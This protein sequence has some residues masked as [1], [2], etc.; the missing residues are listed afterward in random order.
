MIDRRKRTADTLLHL[1]SFGLVG[2]VTIILFSVGSVSLLTTD[3]KPLLTG[4]GGVD[5]VFRHI[6]SN[7]A[8]IPAP[9]YPLALRPTNIPAP[10]P[11]QG[12]SGSATAEITGARSGPELP[13]AEHDAS[14]TTLEVR[15]TALI[16]GFQITNPN[17]AEVGGS[18]QASTEPLPEADEPSARAG[19]SG[20]TA[21]SEIPEGRDHSYH[22]PEIDQNQ[23]ARL[24]QS[25]IISD[26]KVA[27]YKKSG[28]P[29][30]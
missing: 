8:L 6:N 17:P 11:P 24:D 21:P 28:A 14:T 7:A 18:D 26:A 4:S 12:A 19:V 1:V 30:S 27:S 16:Q 13:S 29:S 3:K 22:N 25:N 5:V 23:P 20:P 10:L 2:A 15:D 9:T